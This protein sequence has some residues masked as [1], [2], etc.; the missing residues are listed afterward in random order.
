MLFLTQYQ[1]SLSN[2]DVPKYVHFQYVSATFKLNVNTTIPAL[3]TW[4]QTVISSFG[5]KGIDEAGDYLLLMTEDK[6]NSAGIVL[7]ALATFPGQSFEFTTSEQ[8]NVMY[9]IPTEKSRLPG[10]RPATVCVVDTYS[11]SP[12]PF[13]IAPPSTMSGTVSGTVS[14]PVILATLAALFGYVYYYAK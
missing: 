1:M 3:F 6:M 5:E 8:D 2:E 10:A 13:P 11:R 12:S 7:R 9:I 14:Q 4:L